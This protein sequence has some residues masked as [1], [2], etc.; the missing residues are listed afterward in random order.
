MN[1]QAVIDIA[2]KTLWLALKVGAPALLAS[3]IMGLIVSV[4]QA[5]TQINEQT[6][7]FIPKILAMTAAIFFFGPWMIEAMMNFTISMINAIPN[8]GR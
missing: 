4:F 7:S 6:L 3:M 1:D 8:V 2:W 5:A